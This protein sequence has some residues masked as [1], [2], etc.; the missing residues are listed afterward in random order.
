ETPAHQEDRNRAEVEAK[1]QQNTG[2]I[3]PGRGW[4]DQ[5][6]RHP[7]GVHIRLNAGSLR[8]L[9]GRGHQEQQRHQQAKRRFKPS[10]G[11][12]HEIVLSVSRMTPVWISSSPRRSR[13]PT[14]RDLAVRSPQSRLMGSRSESCRSRLTYLAGGFVGEKL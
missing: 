10:R 7:I 1:N 3:F 13:P 9:G 14:H 2:G 8:H 5:N 12:L 6:L 11:C 4:P